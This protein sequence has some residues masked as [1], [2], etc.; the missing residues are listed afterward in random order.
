MYINALLHLIIFSTMFCVF[1]AYICELFYSFCIRV[2]FH[3]IFKRCK[4]LLE[5]LHCN[6]IKSLSQ[7]TAVTFENKSFFVKFI[8]FNMK[9]R[10]VV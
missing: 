3:K 8:V 10:M 9:I 4:S 2:V 1:L 5:L 7:N 6:V